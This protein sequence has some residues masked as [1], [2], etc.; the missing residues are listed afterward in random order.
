MKFE[1]NSHRFVEVCENWLNFQILRFFTDVVFIL[2]DNIE[3]NIN[4]FIFIYEGFPKTFIDVQILGC[5]VTVLLP[6]CTMGESV[7]TPAK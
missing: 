6:T 4:K 2:K 5:V 1:P 7:V 3:M